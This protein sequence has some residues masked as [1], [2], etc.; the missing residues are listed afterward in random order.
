MNLEFECPTFVC[1]A[2]KRIKKKSRPDAVA[3]AESERLFGRTDPADLVTVCEDCFVAHFP[4]HAKI[5]MPSVVP[6]RPRRPRG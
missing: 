5:V 6:P 3:M 1:Y 4:A 2:C